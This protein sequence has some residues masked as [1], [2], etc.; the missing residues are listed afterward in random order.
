MERQSGPGWKLS[1]DGRKRVPDNYNPYNPE[2]RRS[3]ETIAFREGDGPAADYSVEDMGIYDNV[4]VPAVEGAVAGTA[5]A[6]GTAVVA[7]GYPVN[8]ARMG[9]K[10]AANAMGLRTPSG[11]P[12][13]EKRHLVYSGKSV[14]GDSKSFTRGV[15]N[16]L[17]L[18]ERSGLSQKEKEFAK[19][20]PSD[21]FLSDVQRKYLD[22]RKGVLKGGKTRRVRRAHKR[23]SGRK[24]KGKGKKTRKTRKAKRSRKSRK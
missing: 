6:A 8:Q 4:V 16:L 15:G 10:G 14:V 19:A 22:D 20:N 5:I 11:I 21:D 9:A 3:A 18:R 1:A 13:S 23:K 7:A 2:H 12:D 24:S 17:G